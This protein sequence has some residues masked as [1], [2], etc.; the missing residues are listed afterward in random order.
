MTYF[1]G[2]TAYE[3]QIGRFYVEF[4]HLMGGNWHWYS[5]FS[6]FIFGME[7]KKKC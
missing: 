1:K 2:A 7:E 5:F 6:R 3:L 4:C